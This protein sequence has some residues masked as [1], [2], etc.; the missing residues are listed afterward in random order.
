VSVQVGAGAKAVIPALLGKPPKPFN[1]QK[2]CLVGQIHYRLFGKCSTRTFGA[3]CERMPNICYQPPMRSEGNVVGL[4]AVGS[5]LALELPD[6]LS[7]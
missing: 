3:A 7:I 4:I 6:D 2:T 5:C 1:Q